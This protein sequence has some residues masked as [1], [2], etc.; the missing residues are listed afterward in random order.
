MA[1]RGYGDR[2]RLWCRG[3]VIE[4]QGVASAPHSDSLLRNLWLTFKR[5]ETDELPGVTVGWSFGRRGGE[6][7]TDDEGFFEF[8]FEP[9]DDYD[10]D[11]AWQAVKLRIDNAPGIDVNPVEAEA[12]VRTPPPD[13]GLGIISDIDDTIVV[14][15]AYDFLKHWRTVVANS[16]ESR[17]AFPGIGALYRA[18]AGKDGVADAHPV[19]YVSSSPWN[20]FD[21]FERFMVLN[22]IPVGPMLLKDFGLTR[23]K[24]LTGGHDGHKTQMIEAV[25]QRYPQ[26]TFILV[27]DSGQRDAAIYAD[28]AAKHA[29]RVAA[30]FMREVSGNGDAAHL[31]ALRD[32]LSPLGIPCAIG[33][34]L[35]G[36]A[37]IG[38]EKGWISAAEHDRI[39]AAI[40]EDAAKP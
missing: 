19:F 13:A 33:P 15:G 18:L 21:L 14:T 39:G 10:P 31:R 2:D 28:I 5:Y 12:L 27:G 32:R 29:G 20:L 24:W 22:D 4:D 37:D 38:L 1:Y 16:A 9:G 23:D 25:M 7:V 8:T 35:A 6:V 3:R 40:S 34:D 17:L 11:A 26:M 36:A 30:V